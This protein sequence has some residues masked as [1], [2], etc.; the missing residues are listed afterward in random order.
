[1]ASRSATALRRLAIEDLE[2]PRLAL[3]PLP[4]SS[5]SFW[6]S[7]AL[8]AVLGGGTQ[9]LKVQFTPSGSDYS[10][11]SASVQI[12]VNP[13]ALTIVADSFSQT[14]GS[15]IPPLTAS[16]IGL[17]NGD[18]PASLHGAPAMTTEATPL[19]PWG[20]YPITI[21]Q[22]NLISSNYTF[23]F[24]DGTLVI[25]PAPLTVTAQSLTVTNSS[26]IPNPY[27][28]TISGFVNG[29]TSAVV[30][31]ACGTNAQSYSSSSAGSYTVTPTVGTLSALNYYFTNF[32]PGTLTIS[33]SQVITIGGTNAFYEPWGVAVGSNGNVYVTDLDRSYV[34]METPTKGT[35]TLTE[36]G[37]FNDYDYTVAVDGSGNVY[38]A[39]YGANEVW[40]L[41]YANGS[42]TQSAIAT[43]DD[44]LNGPWGIAVDKNGNIFV[45]NNG[46]S[47]VMEL[48][49][50]S[51]GGFT[52]S[53]IATAAAQGLNGPDG[54]AVDGNGNVYIADAGNERVVIM[55]N[56]AGSY[57]L[58]ST[59]FGPFDQ[60]TGVAVDPNGNV[61]ISAAT[62]STVYKETLSNGA[63]TQSTFL[64]NG[65]LAPSGVAVDANG[66]VYI[67]NTGL[68]DVI[69]VPAGSN[70]NAGRAD[71]GDA[72]D[73]AGT[74]GTIPA[75][76]TAARP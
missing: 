20:Y 36:L 5:P 52:A 37:G 17:V 7:P 33:Q 60:L 16:Y 71:R 65:L 32:T 28:C 3:L 50:A 24:V 23:T 66:N 1:M 39:A 75:R 67:T 54:V 58:S 70:G 18:T 69:E 14:Y 41:T 26:D 40:E 74:R 27:P 11:A 62:E 56:S 72:T 13:V 38:V 44:G 9:T 42:Y 31:G 19:F 76:A 64:A 68:H 25:T 10:P 43:S 34:S 35:F 30:S 55:N 12:Q 8:G 4:C 73:A 59:S 45:A 46:S 49:P 63:Y 48:T 53:T 15:P 29:D 21:T 57:S 22:G 47:N 51:G 61:Y 2:S 6:Y